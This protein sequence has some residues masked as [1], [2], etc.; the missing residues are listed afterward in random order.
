MNAVHNVCITHGAFLPSFPLEEMSLDDLEH[1]ALSPHRFQAVIQKYDGHST[2]PLLTRKFVPRVQ[3]RQSGGAAMKTAIDEMALIP[4]G[5]F[6]LTSTF[7]GN[8]FLWDLGFN[9]G[10]HMKSLPIA[11]L[12][13]NEGSQ[14]VFDMDNFWFNCGPIRADSGGIYVVT[15]SNFTAQYANISHVIFSLRRH[16]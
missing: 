14:G 11:M 3:P 13:T 2:E 15:E 1:T 4:G 16:I 7:S 12:E 9:A 8:L 6:L 10:S 5:R